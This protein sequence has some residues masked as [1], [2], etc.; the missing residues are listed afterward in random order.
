MI[1]NDEPLRSQ[2]IK[3]MIAYVSHLDNLTEWEQNFIESIDAQFTDG[4]K[5]NVKQCEILERLYDKE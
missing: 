3:K 2:M 5:I 4:K 1:A